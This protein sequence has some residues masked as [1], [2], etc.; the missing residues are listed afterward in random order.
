MSKRVTGLAPWRPGAKAQAVLQLAL[1][2][3]V[4][5][6]LLVRRVLY[7]AHERGLFMTKNHTAYDAVSTILGRAR[8]GGLLPWE[9]V[10]E[11]SDR[12]TPMAFASAD[13]LAATVLDAAEHLRLPRQVGQPVHLVA[14]SEH[15]G[16][17]VVLSPTAH[18]YGVEVIYSGGFDSTTVRYSEARK[19][20]GREVPTVVLHF[21]DRD[22]HGEQIV[23]VL[24]RDLRALYG[25]LGGRQV[26]PEVV[27]VALTPTQ[28]AWFGIGQPGEAVQV[29][30]LP[31]PVL[32][33][34][35]E[36]AIVER[37]DGQVRQALLEREEQ[38][39]DEAVRRA[40]DF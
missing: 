40:K 13:D 15:R 28:V 31:T 11:V 6:P 9:A 8:R 23:D 22:R 12:D 7:V 1:D 5:W 25:D 14:W 18:D 39:R 32:R 16:L 24:G 33:D 37:Q 2:L 26:A 35:L 38:A 19:A 3:R 29:D 10:A 17:K 20:V 34:L 27:R 36:A 4:E 21:G 30:A